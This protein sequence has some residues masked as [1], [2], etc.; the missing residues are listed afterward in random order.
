MTL[1]R[2]EK[3]A[4]VTYAERKLVKQ[5]NTRTVTGTVS[6]VWVGWEGEEDYADE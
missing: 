3:D 6:T 1:E 2:N 4:I 5:S